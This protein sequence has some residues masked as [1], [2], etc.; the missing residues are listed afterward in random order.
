MAAADHL[1]DWQFKYEALDTGA[2]KPLHTVNAYTP[3]GSF[4]GTMHWNS[5]HVR[6]IDVRPQYQRQG[7][8]TAMW[9][10]GH[11]V[12]EE[13]SRVP[14]PKHSKDRSDAGDAWAKSVGGR[15]PRRNW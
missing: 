5:R 3:E 14:R 11:S 6:K 1:Q 12:A 8:A 9:E 15:L 13:E 4:A 10:H 7:V 2:S